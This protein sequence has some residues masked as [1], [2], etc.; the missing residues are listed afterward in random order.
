MIFNAYRAAILRM[1]HLLTSRSRALL[2]KLTVS[3]LVKKFPAF[4]GTRRF[5]TAF[6]SARYSILSH[7]VTRQFEGAEL[8]APCPT[9]KLEHHPLSAIR[10]WFNIFAATLHNGGRSSI[11]NLRTRRRGDRDPL[12][13]VT[14][15][16]Y[17]YKMFLY[18]TTPLVGLGPPFVDVLHS[19]S[20]TH[21]L[22]SWTSDGPGA[23]ASTWQHNAHKR[24]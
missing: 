15:S 24:Y 14:T 10:D 6:T 17:V 18:G 21:A 5:I 13:A 12:I 1:N 16:D 11:R 3:Q 23:E 8:L 7:F 2:E 20:R 4:Y 19:H 22:H 9:P